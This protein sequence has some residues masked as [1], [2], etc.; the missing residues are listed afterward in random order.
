MKAAAVS[1]E[2]K[3]EHNEILL[4]TGQHYDKELSKI[5]FEDLKIPAP[6]YNLGVG[7]GSHGVQTAKMLMGIEKIFL[8]EKPEFVMVYGDTNSTIAGALAAVKLQIPIAHVEAGLRSFDWRMPEEINRVLTDHMST[9]L[10][11]PTKTATR[12]LELEGLKKGVHNVGDVMYDILVANIRKSKRSQI[13]KQLGLAPKSFMLATIH[14][15]ENTDLRNNLTNIVNAF[16]DAQELIVFPAHFRTIKFL[17]KYGL[18]KKLERS[19]NVKVIKPVGY[20][21]FLKLMANARKI[22]TD[23]GGIQKE[24]YILAVPCITLRENTEWLE[25]INEGW[26]VLVG[27][28]NTKLIDA[29]QN[30]KP[31]KRIKKLFGD[32]NASLKIR[33]ILDKY[34]F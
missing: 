19:E 31:T 1:K 21:D 9:L 23:S 22:L 20:L 26:N 7:S 3:K 5:F 30:F 29:I 24:S 14:R 32:G 34:S 10:F 11:C 18:N 17:K 13:L 15:Q 16:S 28:D 27:T 4:H 6:K 12:N 2:L 8:H 25:T 33:E